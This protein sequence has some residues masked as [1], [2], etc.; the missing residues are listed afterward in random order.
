MVGE[1]ETGKKFRHEVQLTRGIL[2]SYFSI[3]MKGKGQMRVYNIKVNDMHP[4]SKHGFFVLSSYFYR[5]IV[6]KI[7]KLMLWKHLFSL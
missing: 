7:S 3:H 1:V 4:D 2:A 6:I 5:V